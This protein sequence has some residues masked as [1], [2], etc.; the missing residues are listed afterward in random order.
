VQ[1]VAVPGGLEPPTNGLGNRC[2]V[3]LSYGTLR[4]PCTWDPNLPNPG[5]GVKC[6]KGL[7]AV[8]RARDVPGLHLCRGLRLFFVY[9]RGSELGSINSARWRSFTIS[10]DRQ[11]PAC[12]SRSERRN[13]RRGTQAPSIPKVRQAP[14][15]RRSACRHRRWRG[16]PPRHR[17]QRRGDVSPSAGGRRRCQEC[18]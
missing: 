9:I 2:S 7:A 18:R 8:V 14:S 6:V 10:A 5:A 1:P 13:G 15:P 11:L 16:G 3:L 17:W 12:A 4:F